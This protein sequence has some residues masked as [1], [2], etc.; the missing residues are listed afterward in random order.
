MCDHLFV[1]L[2]AHK[3]CDA[4]GDQNVWATLFPQNNVTNQS[5]SQ[6]SLVI[7]A[8]VDGA[9]LFDD[10]SPAADS[11]ITGLVTLL[12]VI[13]H[14][15]SVKEYLVRD[16]PSPISNVYFILF[17]G[18]AFGYIG[19][20]R[21]VY[22]M[23]HDQFPLK[24]DDVKFF[25]EINQAA[26]RNPNESYYIHQSK[27][28]SKDLVNILTAEGQRLNLSLKVPKQSSWGVPPS[29]LHSFLHER[30]NLS[31]IV[32]TNHEDVYRNKYYNSIFDTKE[33]IQYVYGGGDNVFSIQ[34]KIATLAATVANS[35]MEVLS[36]KNQGLKVTPD[37]N[38]VD[39]LLHCY[40]ET[41]NCTI[42][43]DILSLSPENETRIEPYP[44]YVGVARHVN[45]LTH[46]TKGILVTYL[47]SKLDNVTEEKECYEMEPKGS[48]YFLNKTCW[49]ST[50]VNMTEAKSPA[51]FISDYDWGSGRYS[52]WTESI[53]QTFTV[54]I[55]LKPSLFH[56]VMTL[57]SGVTVFLLSMLLVR[58][59]N[60]RKDVIFP[61]RYAGYIPVPPD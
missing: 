15:G 4:L 3:A 55:F 23:T 8:R 2:H 19:S 21:M 61:S 43:R 33:K 36:I 58:Y 26:L 31:G 48:F 10:I 37:K 16:S 22:D 14:L 9:S 49:E 5:Q 47:G 51:F 13:K 28:Q 12:S 1:L 42:F 32:I 53:W 17:N 60:D 59:V 35:V 40:L 41:S 52:T 7:A 34:E 45:P 57:V 50:E 18:E 44:M 25:V 24:L 46:F 30:P 11:A 38:T 39:E 29:S 20:S 54:R 6:P 56:E 27:A